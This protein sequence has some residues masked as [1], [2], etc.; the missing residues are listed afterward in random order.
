MKTKLSIWLIYIDEKEHRSSVIAVKTME[1]LFPMP[2]QIGY[3]ID[4]Q[5]IEEICLNSENSD[6][7]DIKLQ[8]I[9][10]TFNSLE[11]LKYHFNGWKIIGKQGE[12]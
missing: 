11:D 7:I 2:P 5:K 12:I 6:I 3:K 1:W 8:Q 9:Y 10:R 4:G